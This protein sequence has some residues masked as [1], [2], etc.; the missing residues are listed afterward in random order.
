LILIASSFRFRGKTKKSPEQEA[1]EK[2]EII[3]GEIER[4]YTSLCNV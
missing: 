4:Q 3:K 2:E 1:E